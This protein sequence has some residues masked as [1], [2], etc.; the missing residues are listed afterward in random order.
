MHPSLNQHGAL[1]G[2]LLRGHLSA[3]T[4]LFRLTRLRVRDVIL[5]R[6]P[7]VGLGMRVPSDRTAADHVHLLML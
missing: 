7:M 5:D 6:C 2:S 4:Q 3:R 1:C